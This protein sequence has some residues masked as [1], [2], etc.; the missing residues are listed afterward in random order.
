MKCGNC[1]YSREFDVA[2]G[3]T[4]CPDCGAVV[5]NEVAS[6]LHAGITSDNSEEIKQL[7]NEQ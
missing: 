5:D 2:C 1:G 3:Q 6:A 7:G 4:H